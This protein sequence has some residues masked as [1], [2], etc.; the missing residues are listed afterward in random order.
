MIKQLNRVL[1]WIIE[2]ITISS[3]V[4]IAQTPEALKNVMYKAL[5]V[6]NE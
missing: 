1:Q 4:E 3:A 2:M 6:K 5:Q